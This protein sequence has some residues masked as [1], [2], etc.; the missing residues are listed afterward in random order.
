MINF[1]ISIEINLRSRKEVFVIEIN[2]VS[3]RMFFLYFLF[4]LPS[5][6]IDLIGIEFQ[7]M[8]TFLE[9]SVN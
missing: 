5:R 6:I 1:K 4:S 2:L 9:L 3:I 8:S 7:L